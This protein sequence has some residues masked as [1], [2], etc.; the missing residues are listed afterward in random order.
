M[1]LNKKYHLFV[2]TSTVSPGTTE[3]SLI[4]VIEK[5]S[6]RKI[7]NVFGVAY[8]PE[9]IALGEV[10]N[11]FL[12]P[13]LLLIGQSNGFVGDQLEKIYKKTCENKPYIARMSIISAE[14]TKISLNA[15]VTMK[16]S[17]ANNLANICERVPGADIDDITKA[18]GAD[19]RISPFYLKGGPAFGGPCF[20]RDGRAF[21]SFARKNGIA[22][23]LAEA[24]DEI[25]RYQ[26]KHLTETVFAEVKGKRNKLVS[27]LGLAYKP[28]TSV[29]EESAAIKLI[30]GLLKYGIK[31]SVYDSLAIE[32]TK[33]L[34]GDK[35]KY[36]SSAKECVAVAPVCVITTPDK[37]FQMFGEAGFQNRKMTVIDCWRILDPAKLGKKVKYIGWGRVKENAA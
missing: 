6:G 31:V 32:N 12:N 17:Y 13:D 22:A 1:N 23:K 18:L 37:E 5:Y 34:F 7:N 35:I 8:N 28:K 2:I 14:I 25:N 11:G 26:V 27:V 24:T 29:I 15:Y 4:P 19:K 9:F 10:I 36:A 33:V 21:V 16:I 30:E 20:P 3:R